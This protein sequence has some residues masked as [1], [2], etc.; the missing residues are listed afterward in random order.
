MSKET[1]NATIV[2]PEALLAFGESTG[3][4]ICKKGLDKFRA[5]LNGESGCTFTSDNVDL[6]M[7][8]ELPLFWLFKIGFI[9]HSEEHRNVTL[10]QP[11]LAYYYALYV[12]KKPNNLTRSAALKDPMSAFYYAKH[13]DK[14][15]R[16]D[17][18]DATQSNYYW[19]LAY[20]RHFD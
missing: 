5:F 13:V 7:R 11:E 15:Q 8:A 14:I 19:S 17:T 3:L 20:S 12:E 18:K 9:K 10:H 16:A 4:D 1:K 6:A 2:S